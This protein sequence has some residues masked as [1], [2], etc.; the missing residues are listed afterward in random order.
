MIIFLI[1]STGVEFTRT[2]YHESNLIKTQHVVFHRISHNCNSDFTLQIHSN[3]LNA[4]FIMNATIKFI[5]NANKNDQNIYFV[6]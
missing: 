1:I 6:F 4:G 5:D 2:L 3:I